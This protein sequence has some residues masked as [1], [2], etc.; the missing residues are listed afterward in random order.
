[1]FECFNSCTIGYSNICN[2]NIHLL[3]SGFLYDTANTIAIKPITTMTVTKDTK[4]LSPLVEGSSLRWRSKATTMAGVSSER[5][6]DAKRLSF[7][8][9]MALDSSNAIYVADYE[10]SRVQKW[11]MN[12]PRAMTLDG[13]I[14]AATNS[15]WITLNF[16]TKVTVDLNGNIYVTDSEAH[17][18]QLWL[19][20]GSSWRTVAGT[21]KMLTCSIDEERI[22]CDALFS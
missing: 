6:N 17:R 21:G 19:N 1:M 22:V 9:G 8:T 4:N 5:G 20:G 7:C 18:V 10:N 16:P 15:T 12:S 14:Y 11:T 3:N 13:Q 2:S